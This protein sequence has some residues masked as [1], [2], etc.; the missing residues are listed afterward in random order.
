M[1]K[2]DKK[3]KNMKIKAKQNKNNFELCPEY[4]GVAKIVDATELR[5]YETQYGDK[6][7]FRFILE[8]N[9]KDKNGKYLTVA[10]KPLTPSY[11]EKASLT[12]FTQQVLGR[13]L[14]QAEKDDGFDPEDL[15]GKYVQIIVEHVPSATMTDKFYANI[16]FVG[17]T[18]STDSWK[19]EYVRLS[20]KKAGLEEK[21]AAESLQ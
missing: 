8:V 20:E 18:K 9:Q 1:L 2:K 7:Q 11:H 21:K 10:T 6:E 5:E 15:I 19:S 3:Q 4:T 13:P 17:K 16:T 12:K 14:T